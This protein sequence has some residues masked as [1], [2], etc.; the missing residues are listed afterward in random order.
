MKEVELFEHNE[1]A[2]KKLCD[3]LESSRYATINHA[4]GT[5]KSFISLKY[6][7]EHRDKKF[8]Y[9]TPTYPIINQLL[10]DCSKIGIDKEEL[11]FDQIIYRTLL[12]LDPHE[13]FE[14]YDGFILDEYHRA[15]AKETYKKIRELKNLIDS[16]KSK[17]KKVI[18][19]TATP[20][21]YLDDERDMTDEIFDGNVASEISL[22]QAMIDGL[23]PI[24]TYISTKI[25]FL[26]EY[27]K[28]VKMLGRMGSGEEKKKIEK[29]LKVILKKIQEDETS[30]KDLLDKN[31]G[32]KDGKF[33]VFCDT[34]LDAERYYRE[35]DRW[36]SGKKN[37]SK[38]IIHSLNSP[39]DRQLLL[40]DFN[41]NK[42]GTSALFCVDILN[43]GVHASGV[44]RV[45]ML[46]RTF[47]PIIYFQ[48]IGRALSYSGRNRDVKIYDLVTNFNNSQAISAVYDEFEEEIYK[49]IEQEP[50]NKEKYMEMLSKF[51]ILDETKE[52]WQEL[53]SI[54]E[55]LTPQRMAESRINQSIDIFTKFLSRRKS[56][57][58]FILDSSCKMQSVKNAYF[59]LIQDY[60]YVTNEQFDR[61]KE[62]NMLL[63]AEFMMTKEERMNYLNGADSIY[64]YKQQNIISLTNM[65]ADQKEKIRKAIEQN[66][67]ECEVWEKL[68]LDIEIDTTNDFDILMSEAEEYL[69]QKI[70]LPD[71]LRKAVQN[72]IYKY[73]SGRHKELFEILDKSD[74]IERKD[75]EIK[76]EKRRL[77]IRKVAKFL[78]D[79]IELTGEELKSKD[80]LKELNSMHYGDRSY[81]LNRF[82]KS[83]KKM[84]KTMIGKKGVDLTQIC[85]DFKNL[86]EDEILDYF[87]S[88]A[89]EVKD[90]RLLE[91]LLSDGD[92][93]SIR[94]LI[95]NG[96]LSEDIMAFYL[97][98]NILGIDSKELMSQ[99]CQEGIEDDKQKMIALREIGFIKTNGRRP[100]SNSLDENERK[101]ASELD[102]LLLTL[103]KKDADK[104][105]RLFTT[106]EAIKRGSAQYAKN[107]RE[108]E[109]EER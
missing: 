102:K 31:E 86:E 96:F 76:Y 54:E 79:N 18:G 71:Y 98:E 92:E 45:L 66:D 35:S 4:T 100:L 41:D 28:V 101:L 7:Y 56:S 90:Y 36:F 107:I 104:I 3:L 47:S 105:R 20:K 64:E 51:R 50:Q 73:N 15:G 72:A 16:D 34:I 85:R 43:E 63:P 29:R 17:S 87:N 106:T 99:I 108:K 88:V 14:K 55:K 44:N 57:D 46:R 19:L 89:D 95:E 40:D 81:V 53:Q 67:I 5:G 30:I 1:I 23:L 94:M 68:L 70:A 78:D 9:I 74:A 103:S 109:K 93:D 26:S 69:S 38:Y 39:K 62:L 32:S 84:F 42:E 37:Y 11:N 24:P 91:E 21:R 61:L 12:D 10:N 6:L 60:E 82:R 52:I 83:R 13:L 25:S 48:Q 8:L 49:R 65:D 27:D 2:Y 58:I 75:N 80:E 59:T 33:I 97:E 77:K 22:A